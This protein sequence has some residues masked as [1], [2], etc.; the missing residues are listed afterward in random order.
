MAGATQEV[1]VCPTDKHSALNL[2]HLLHLMDLYFRIQTTAGQ[3]DPQA[4]QGDSHT[5]V[6]PALRRLRQK[7][8]KF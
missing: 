7:D 8:H 4:G 1:E 3:G 6:I 2:P 5:S